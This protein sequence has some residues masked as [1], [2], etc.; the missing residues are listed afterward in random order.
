MP[1]DR[2]RLYHVEKAKGGLAHDDDRRHR[3]RLARQSAGVRQPARLRRRDRAVDPGDDRRHPRARRGGDDPDQPPRPAHRVGPGRLAA[4]R[5]SVA[6]ARAGAP[7]A[8]ED[9]R[10]VGHRPHRR[11]LRRRR[12]ADEGR[13]DGRHRDRGLRPPVRPVLVAGHQPSRR[14]VRR[15][16]RQPHALPAARAARDPGARRADYIV[17][18]RM[19]VDERMEDGIDTPV[20]LEILRRL[21]APRS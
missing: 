15:L 7:V 18:I 13:R 9:R 2:Y 8:P 12:R 3:D 17:G 19:A 1:K 14:R 21:D 10:A 20:G 16:V 5:R 11:R 6:A 4:G